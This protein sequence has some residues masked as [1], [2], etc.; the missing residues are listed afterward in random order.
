M[1]NCTKNM[2]WIGIHIVVKYQMTAEVNS[3]NRF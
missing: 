3:K 2:G 1:E